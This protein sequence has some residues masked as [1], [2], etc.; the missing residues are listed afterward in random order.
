[1]GAAAVVVTLRR[2]N[3]QTT[4]AEVAIPATGCLEVQAQGAATAIRN[5]NVDAQ[6]VTQELR[7]GKA[8]AILI[9][10][11]VATMDF[12]SQA[13]HA[14]ERKRAVAMIHTA[15]ASAHRRRETG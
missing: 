2:T 7:I 3:A 6:M 12:S 9:V 10:A 5:K 14:T 1:M 15:G 8:P 11:Q 4:C 13:T